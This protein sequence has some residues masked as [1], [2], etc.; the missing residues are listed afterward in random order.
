MIVLDRPFGGVGDPVVDFT[1]V[2]AV[3]LDKVT[4]E[5]IADT[6]ALAA[7]INDYRPLAADVVKTVQNRL[8]GERIYNSNAIEGNTLTLRETVGILEVGAVL[9]VHK[10]RE[11]QE[12]L[13][14]KDAIDRAQQLAADDLKWRDFAEFLSV[15][16]RLLREIENASADRLRLEDIVLTGAKHQPPD[17]S[18][19]PGL[20][21]SLFSQV[22]GVDDLDAIH[23]AT[24]V[25]WAITRIHPFKDG[26][27]RMARLW[28]DLVLFRKNLTSAI[29]RQ[30][31]RTEYYSALTAADDGDFNPLAQM[32]SQRVCAT[33]QVSE[34][35]LE[36]VLESRLN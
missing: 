14:L 24:W 23:L 34:H 1:D 16:E 3:H 19:V 30:Q 9:N 18:H 5:L 33:L 6:H 8:L 26:N 4:Q 27:G 12:F 15:H 10:K 17:Q 25:H 29:I 21:N 11:A 13:G 36:E 32:I 7:K 28:Q 31:N 2:R 35:F 22:A 20:M